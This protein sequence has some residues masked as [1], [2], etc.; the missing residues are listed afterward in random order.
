MILDNGPWAAALSP[1]QY[2]LVSFFL[3]AGV[4]AFVAAT[5]RTWM[6]QGEVGARYRSAAVA[7]LG[8]VGTAAISY[9]LMLAYFTFGYSFDGVNWIPSELAVHSFSSRYM[10][11]VV[12]VPLLAV[13]LLAVCTVVGVAARKRR[14]LAFAGSAVMIF[15]GY[16]G[17]F[18]V[19]TSDI[20]AFVIWFGVAS[21]FYILTV[22]V[23]FTSVRHSL[24]SLTRETGVLLVRASTLL[25]AGWAVYPLIAVIQLLPVD[26]VWAT[27]MQVSLSIADISIKIGFGT[28]IH[29][30][31]KQRTAEDVRAGVDVHPESV[32]VSSVKLSDAGKPREVYLDDNAV[33]HDRR[34][35]PPTSVAIASKVETTAED[36]LGSS[37]LD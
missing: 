4:L 20:P 16:V 3:T 5:I 11:W 17:A 7:R 1:A 35:K 6:T 28:L 13:E 9:G 32:W 21:L 29:R 37:I 34:S 18:M 23:L 8:V 15:T 22:I 33:V 24:P 30:V 12:S 36:D 26:G 14:A 31:A 19:G 10:G 2:M 25:L 27:T